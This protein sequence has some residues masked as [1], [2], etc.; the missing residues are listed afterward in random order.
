MSPNHSNRKIQILRAIAI[1]A[2]VMCH[3]YPMRFRGVLI[4]SLINFAVP[5]FL[6]LSGYLTKLEYENW[7]SFWWKRIKR[8]LIPYAVW[9]VFWTVI[10]HNY[11][12][13]LF[14]LLTGKTLYPYYY[15]FVYCQFVIFTPLI[16]KL[17]KSKYQ[18]VGWLIQPLAIYLR[19]YCGL[20]IYINVYLL[21]SWFGSYYLGLLLGNHLLQWKY[22]YKKTIALCVITFVIS[23]MEGIY[24]Y[25][26]GNYDLATNTLNLTNCLYSAA[27]LLLAYK[28]IIDDRI[29]V[30]D[31]F[32]NRML[33]TLGDYSFGIFLIH[34]FV[35]MVMRKLTI[36]QYLVFPI[37]S[38]IAVVISAACVYCGRKIFGEKYG[39]YLG[40]Y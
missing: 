14:K 33:I 25:K 29:I 37:N 21:F 16:A 10:S 8:I 7:G 6:F 40:F 17:A 1:C 35:L 32:V 13:F 4:R 36:Y 38:A 12:D 27:C 18:W 9:S 24:W 39:K 2:V 23:S 22:N 26:A 3:S 15:V 28:F 30:D 31:R 34:A 5:M 20:E 11:D 19:K